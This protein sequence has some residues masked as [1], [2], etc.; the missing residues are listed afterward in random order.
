MNYTAVFFN[1]LLFRMPFLTALNNMSGVIANTI[2]SG[3]VSPF[4]NGMDSNLYCKNT[5]TAV[6]IGCRKKSRNLTMSLT[7]VCIKYSNIKENANTNTSIT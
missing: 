2:I 5:R 3:N 4:C 1:S 7:P 6:S